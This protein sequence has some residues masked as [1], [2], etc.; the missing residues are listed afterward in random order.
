MW[1]ER[2]KEWIIVWIRF[3]V[4]E[5]KRF[6]ESSWNQKYERVLTVPYKMQKV[7][8]SVLLEDKKKSNDFFKWGVDKEL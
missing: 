7:K 8:L 4:L 6:R 3:P 1:V 2:F 5:I